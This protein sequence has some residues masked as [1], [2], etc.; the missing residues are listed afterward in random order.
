MTLTQ[1]EPSACHRMRGCGCAFVAV[2]QEASGE[3]DPDRPPEVHV[4]RGTDRP[5]LV[6]NRGGW[7]ASLL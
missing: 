1:K 2:P 3:S 5:G 6:H 4:R 7:R